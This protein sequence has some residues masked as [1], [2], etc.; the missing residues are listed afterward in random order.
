MREKDLVKLEELKQNS[1]SAN[2]MSR[3]FTRPER[4]GSPPSPPL[5]LV[6]PALCSTANLSSAIDLVHGDRCHGNLSLNC[7]NLGLRATQLD[8][9]VQTSI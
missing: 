8:H 6:L 4:H 3:G 5:L 7:S 2:R 1:V 9:N